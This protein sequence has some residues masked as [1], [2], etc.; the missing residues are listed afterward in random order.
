M[1]ADLL[2]ISELEWQLFG[3]FTFKRE[4]PSEIAF[5]MWMG[6]VR[7][8]AKFSAVHFRKVLWALR[9]ERGEIGGRFHFHALIGGYPTW[10]LNRS[11]NFACMHAWSEQGGGHSRIWRY[12]PSLDGVG[13]IL[14][15]LRDFTSKHQRNGV[16]LKDR[17]AGECYEATKLGNT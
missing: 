15:H 7:L 6:W 5:K 14:K 10:C 9:C 2:V 4:C 1:K 16:G 13:Y 11:F 8:S 12:N 17:N 3:T